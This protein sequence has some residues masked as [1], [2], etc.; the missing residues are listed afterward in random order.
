MPEDGLN[1]EGPIEDPDEGS[2]ELSDSEYLRDLARRLGHVP[3]AFWVDGYDQDRL[4]ELAEKND[5]DEANFVQFTDCLR[6]VG[7]RLEHIEQTVRNIERRVKH[8]HYVE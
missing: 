5:Q 6:E 2:V 1:L 3:T 8:L 4:L 7:R